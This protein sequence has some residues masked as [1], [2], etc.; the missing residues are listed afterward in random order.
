MKNTKKLADAPTELKA[1]SV[2]YDMSI[3]E[4]KVLAEKRKQARDEN[5]KKPNF[6]HKV[7]GPPWNLRIIKFQKRN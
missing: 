2:A 1:L 5:A 6:I 4:L 7:R 3:D